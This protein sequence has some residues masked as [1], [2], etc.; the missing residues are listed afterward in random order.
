MEDIRQAI[1]EAEREL[2]AA[3]KAVASKRSA[4]MASPVVPFLTF[5]FRLGPTCTVLVNGEAKQHSIGN[6]RVL[7]QTI[8]KI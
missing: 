1:S 3:E 6:A 7:L 2:E 5:G 8:C 4:L